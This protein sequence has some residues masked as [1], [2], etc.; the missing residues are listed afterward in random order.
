M[1]LRAGHEVGDESAMRASTSAVARALKEG[2]G[3]LVEDADRVIAVEGVVAVELLNMVAAVLADL[4]GE[5]FET[6]AT[7][8]DVFKARLLV[9]TSE[10]A[11][12]AETKTF[13]DPMPGG[14]R[15][16]AILEARMRF[17]G[18]GATNPGFR[19]V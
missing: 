5:D 12:C 1:L 9:E 13:S 4:D 2:L 18:N 10:M 7:S 6:L 11:V 17:V 14:I 15:A 8:E 19:D 3:L 16:L